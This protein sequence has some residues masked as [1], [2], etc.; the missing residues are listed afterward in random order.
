MNFINTM[1]W[2]EHRILYVRLPFR[3]WLRIRR[4]PWRFADAWHFDHGSGHI[5]HQW[6][7][8]FQRV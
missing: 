7:F 6:T 4:V 1:D 8:T 3:W 2:Q 5:A